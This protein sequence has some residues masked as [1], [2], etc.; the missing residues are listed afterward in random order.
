VEDDP[1]GEIRFKGEPKNSFY[2]YLPEQTILLGTFSKTVVP[3]FRMGWIVAPD[4]VMDRLIVAKQAADLHTDY[5]TQR[6]VY[7]YLSDYDIDRHIA[8]I[9]EA[10]GRQAEAMMQAIEHYFPKDIQYTRPEGGM[11]LWLTLPEGTNA[12]DLFD[13][14]VKQNVAFVPG[15][16]FYID[17]TAVNTCR[18]NFSCSNEAEIEEGI[19][20]LSGVL[21]MLG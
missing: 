9:C 18:L 6:L 19:R 13:L 20:R 21:A 2:H 3:A 14:A 17:K 10:Y 8:R 5:F 1:Y 12:L 16:P 11:F 4:A 15:N 7:Q